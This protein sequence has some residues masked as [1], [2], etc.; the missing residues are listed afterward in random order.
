MIYTPT[1]QDELGVVIH[2][3]E[4]SYSFVIGRD[5]KK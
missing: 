4:Q 1:T 5:L 2:L 3:V